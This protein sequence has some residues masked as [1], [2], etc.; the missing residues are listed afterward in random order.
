MII[1]IIFNGFISYL[2]RFII[3]FS[4]II[5]EFIP[6]IIIFIQSKFLSSK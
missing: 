5:I 1:T 6:Q 2:S 4:L 3:E